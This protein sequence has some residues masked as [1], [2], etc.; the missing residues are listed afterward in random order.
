MR[1]MEAFPGIL[2][3]VLT[4]RHFITKTGYHGCQRVYMI[5]LSPEQE[6]WL[7]RWFPEVENS[8]LMKAS[9]LSHSTL[10]RFASQLG[11]S[12]S[13]KGLRG[14]LRRQ[15]KKCKQVNERNGYYDSL[16]GK[17]VSE[18]CQRGTRK[19]WEDIKSG[20][21]GHPYDVF[22]KNHPRRYKAMMEKKSR[23]RKEL[24]KKEYRRMIYGLERQT[25]LT[26]LV[27]RKYTKSQI[28][29]RY[30]AMKRGYIL[31]DDCSDEGG[32]RYNIYYDENSQRGE[33]F[34]QNLRKDGFILKP[35]NG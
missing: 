22:R 14:I 28:G 26:G 21:R 1:K 20:L 3:R 8:V 7:S 12:K 17:P 24:V 33:R 19:M 34:E 4:D 9:G 35:W 10:H 11:L 30:N 5:V 6:A 25:K 16:R 15:T 31:Y 23:D 18:E 13:E 2:Q 29:H 32:E 27:L